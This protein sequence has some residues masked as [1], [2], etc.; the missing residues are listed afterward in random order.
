MVFHLPS[1]YLMFASIMAAA[2]LILLG[3]VDFNKDS[4]NSA[5]ALFMFCHFAVMVVDL[6][7]EGKYAQRMV[8]VPFSGSDCVTWV[9]ATY[10]LGGLM[11]GL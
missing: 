3:S 8:E 6:L 5:A 7:C 1:F 11:Y 2:V 4:A 9:W 10:M